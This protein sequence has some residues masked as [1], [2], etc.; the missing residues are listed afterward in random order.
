[1]LNSILYQAYNIAIY[2][3]MEW[4]IRNINVDL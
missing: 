3:K 4:I 2:Q 1:L